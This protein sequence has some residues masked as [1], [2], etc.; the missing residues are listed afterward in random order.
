MRLYPFD[1]VAIDAEERVRAGHT[2]HQQ[3]EC[4]HCGVKQTMAEENQMFTTGKCEECGGITNIRSKG[5]NYLLVMNFGK[6]K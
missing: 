1:E 2:I 6:E 3:F 4:E 5:C